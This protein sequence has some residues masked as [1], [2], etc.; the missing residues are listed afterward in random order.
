MI[1][2]VRSLRQIAVALTVLIGLITFTAESPSTTALL[3]AVLTVAVVAVA[4]ARPPVAPEPARRSLL[5]HALR[6]LL[7]R[8][9][10]SDPDAR[11]HV[12]PRAP[13]RSVLAV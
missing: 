1:A 3:A 11:G 4:F 5:R 12:R 6:R 8:A 10:Q 2:P 13:G 9:A 7:V